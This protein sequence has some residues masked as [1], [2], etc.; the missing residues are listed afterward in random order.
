M[1]RLVCGWRMREDTVS[2]APSRKGGN[3][4]FVKLLLSASQ[5]VHSGLSLR[6]STLRDDTYWPDTRAN[7]CEVVLCVRPHRVAWVLSIFFFKG[8]D[9]NLGSL[10]SPN[11][12]ELL[13]CFLKSVQLWLF[14]YILHRENIF[15]FSWKLSLLL[16]KQIYKPYSMERFGKT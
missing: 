6:W 11:L 5:E 12:M 4:L 14:S 7:K 15:S 10:Q 2:G 16:A 13:K 8:R 1:E 3:L 9:R